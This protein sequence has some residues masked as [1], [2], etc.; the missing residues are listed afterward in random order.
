MNLGETDGISS[1]AYH[2]IKQLRI[3]VILTFKHAMMPPNLMLEK[4]N[5]NID[6]SGIFVL[7]IQSTGR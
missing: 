1:A 4:L 7:R 3:Q 6:L 5:P 2:V